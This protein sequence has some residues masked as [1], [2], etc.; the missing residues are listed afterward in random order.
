M[1]YGAAGEVVGGKHC[2]A[3]HPNTRLPT[4]WPTVAKVLEK[5]S[6][7][8]SAY[9]ARTPA[10]ASNPCPATAVNPAAQA[11]AAD[12]EPTEVAATTATSKGR[13]ASRTRVISQP[14]TKAG[15]VGGGAV[16][17]RQ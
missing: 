10:S 4:A 13:V 5:A 8:P 2:A 9:T 7:K 11:A 14:R 1:G 12:R 6:C 17:V 15:R 3:I 16:V